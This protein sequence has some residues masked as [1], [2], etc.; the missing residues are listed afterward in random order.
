MILAAGVGERLRPLTATRPKALATIANIPMISGTIRRLQAAGVDRIVVNTHHLPER[1][2]SYL[3]EIDEPGL[4]IKISREEQIL[5]TGGGLGRVHDYL[6]Y[7]PFILI[8]A[9]ILTDIDSAGLWDH[10]L[11]SGNLATL[12]VHDYPEYNQVALDP[13]QRLLG[14]GERLPGGADKIAARVAFTGMHVL[15]PDIFQFL[16]QDH[17]ADIIDIY[18]KLVAEGESIGACYFQDHYWIDIGNPEKY[19][20]AHLDLAAGLF[21]PLKALGRPALLPDLGPGTSLGADVSIMG[22][23]AVGGNCRIGDGAAL[24]NSV[25]WDNTEIGS[26]IHLENCIVGEGQCVVRSAVGE[27]IA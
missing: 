21:D 10:H 24:V 12:A 18:L 20:Q 5:G 9:D 4:E 7:E 3:D 19:L 17:P 13:D 27:V 15:S 1:V 2:E 6:E 14:V 11:R 23:S 8:N 16:P 26:D 22:A 25:I